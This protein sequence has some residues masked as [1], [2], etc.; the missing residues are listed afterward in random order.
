MKTVIVCSPKSLP[1]GQLIAAARTAVEINPHNHPPLARLASMMPGFR[2]TPARIAVLTRKYWGIQGVN[3]TVG[4]LDSPP[5][6]LRERILLHMNAWAKTAN[7]KFAEIKSIM[8]YR[9]PGELTKDGEPFIGGKDIDS[10]DAGFA[11]SIYPKTKKSSSRSRSP[12]QG[13]DRKGNDS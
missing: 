3:L 5:L 11:A 10:S 13:P 8:C 6:E 7:V 9:I 1:D 4:F 12:G 2:A